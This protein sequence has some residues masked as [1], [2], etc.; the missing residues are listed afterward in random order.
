MGCR[1]V[2]VDAAGVRRRQESRNKSWRP[3]TTAK[4]ADRQE[5]A[6]GGGLRG[7]RVQGS[8][9]A[10]MS[11]ALPVCLPRVSLRNSRPKIQ[12]IMRQL[13]Q[14]VVAAGVTHETL[15]PKALS[16]TNFVSCDFDG[17]RKGIGVALGFLEKA[18]EERPLRLRQRALTPPQRLGLS[19]SVVTI[20]GLDLKDLVV[21][22]LVVGGLSAGRPCTSGVVVGNG[23]ALS[24]SFA[25][26]GG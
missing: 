21:W 26:G 3:P 17:G 7:S 24:I 11:A 16:G 10:V 1:V 12:R 22:P 4:V 18:T 20:S 2:G 19:L 14:P 25:N 23:P 9:L 6:F 5:A 8:V 15:L 13:Q